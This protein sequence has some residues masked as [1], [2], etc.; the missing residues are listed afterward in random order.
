MPEADYCVK[1][2]SSLLLE[3]AVKDEPEENLNITVGEFFPRLIDALEDVSIANLLKTISTAKN[4]LL[5]P[6]RYAVNLREGKL[7]PLLRFL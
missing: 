1:C 2:G 3:S 4:I 5:H 6:F 7:A